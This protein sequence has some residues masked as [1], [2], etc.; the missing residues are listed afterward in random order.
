MTWLPL[1]LGTLASTAAHAG[2]ARRSA[3]MQKR[4]GK[5][6]AGML[7]PYA[8]AGSGALA[9]LMSELGL[10]EA[11]EGYGGYSESPMARYLLEKG[12]DTIDASAA[13]R[14]GLYS[15]A[16]LSAL[17]QMR[18][19][20]VARDRD[21]YL[22]QLFGLSSAG[23]NAAAGVGNITMN[24]AAGV[25]NAYQNAANAFSGGLSDMAGMYGYFGGFDE[26]G[27]N[28]MTAYSNPWTAGR[29]GPMGGR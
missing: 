22:A 4:A 1:L 28:P 13:A 8:E 29:R 5:K 24:K 6:A 17:E 12:R 21:N 14:G 23:Q 19:D 7:E 18:G 16:T 15:G 3:K 27:P 9:A 2:A 20:V 25:G 11:P 10:G 26:Q